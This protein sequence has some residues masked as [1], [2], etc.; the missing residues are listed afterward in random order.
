MSEPENKYLKLERQYQDSIDSQ[1]RYFESE[2]A[3][4]KAK[5]KYETEKLK[6][7]K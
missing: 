2:I 3:L 5:Y 6:I 7:R 4:I 1:R